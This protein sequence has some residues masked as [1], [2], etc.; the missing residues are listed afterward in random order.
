MAEGVRFEL[1][2]VI[3]HA[4]FQDRCLKPLG[5]P[6]N[7]ANFST[8]SALCTNRGR[9]KKRLS[10]GAAVTTFAACCLGELVDLREIRPCD[11]DEHALANAVAIQNV[12][13]A[14]ADILQ[15]DRE[16]AAII[17]IDYAAQHDYLVPDL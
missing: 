10:T 3:R 13:V 17:A 11:L 15:M 4:G 5:H 8:K 9:G 2:V 12:I 1:T 14:I 7:R 16:L 6:S